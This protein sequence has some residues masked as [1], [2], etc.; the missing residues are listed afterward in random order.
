MWPGNHAHSIS[1]RS[2]ILRG[3][4]GRQSGVVLSFLLKLLLQEGVNS[5]RSK[6][7]SRNVSLSGIPVSL[8]VYGHRYEIK[9]WTSISKVKT[10]PKFFVVSGDQRISLNGQQKK[11][12]VLLL[13]W[14]MWPWF[15][16]VLWRL[17]EERTHLVNFP[18]IGRYVGEFRD[19]CKEILQT[20]RPWINKRKFLCIGVSL[21]EFGRLVHPTYECCQ[22]YTVR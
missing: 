6:G 3:H 1:C 18:I 10:F 5:Y 20:S 21:P 4:T 13:L 14:H 16:W 7:I 11:N 22:L 12:D 8:Q 9:N 19:S 2:D 17:M 15:S